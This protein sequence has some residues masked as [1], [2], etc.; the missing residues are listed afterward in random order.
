MI[1]SKCGNAVDH[2]AYFCEN[3]GKQVRKEAV[4]ID[5]SQLTGMA[6]WEENYIFGTMAAL[7][8]S[9]AGVAIFYQWYMIFGTQFLA[10]VP[11]FVLGGLTAGGYWWLGKRLKGVGTA[12]CTALVLAAGWLA[13]H[14]FWALVVYTNGIYAVRTFWEVLWNMGT[15]FDTG[16]LDMPSYVMGLV[17][18]YFGALVA[19]A[20]LAGAY[21]TVAKD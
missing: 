1:C 14:I 19:V 5:K 13:N 21:R 16:Y 12:I 15:Y 4:R 20:V 17:G 11:G 18:I 2:E 9:A 8:G 6:L 7:L 3:C 10:P